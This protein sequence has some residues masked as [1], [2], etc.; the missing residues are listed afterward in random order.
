[1]SKQEQ[2]EVMLLLCF[3]YCLCY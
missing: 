3:L 1:L 2:T